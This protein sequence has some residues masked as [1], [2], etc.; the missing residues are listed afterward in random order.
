MEIKKFNDIGSIWGI[1]RV[2]PTGWEVLIYLTN[3]GMKMSFMPKVI[4][5]I[6]CGIIK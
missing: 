2:S 6:K 3:N 1:E 5:K 4:K